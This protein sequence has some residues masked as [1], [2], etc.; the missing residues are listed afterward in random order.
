MRVALIAA[1]TLLSGCV[2]EAEEIPIVV[3]FD[4]RQ[5]SCAGAPPFDHFFFEEAGVVALHVLGGTG[6]DAPIFA[7][8]CTSIPLVPGRNLTD[9]PGIL[10]E[11]AKVSG[12]PAGVEAQLWIAVYAGDFPSCDRYVPGAG[13]VPLIVGHSGWEL[14]DEPV[15]EIFVVL[16]CVEE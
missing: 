7:E 5:D 3:R 16:A 6:A 1:V 12:I 9:L 2:G 15:E 8:S 14:L 10:A 13:K 11:G 4:Y